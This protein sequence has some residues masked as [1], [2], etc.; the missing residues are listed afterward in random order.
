LRDF[1]A[2]ENLSA[3][4]VKRRLEEEC[5]LELHSCFI[6]GSA[7]RKFILDS[8]ACRWF[9]SFFMGRKT[10]QASFELNSMP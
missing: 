2:K 5:V 7:L 9:A 4:V 6:L 10:S 8:V 1:S 3:E